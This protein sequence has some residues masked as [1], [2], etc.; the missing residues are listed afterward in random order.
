MYTHI[1]TALEAG[2]RRKCLVQCR[3]TL[4]LYLGT[5]QR[6]MT[7]QDRIRL[8]VLCCS[9]SYDNVLRERCMD[10]WMDGLLD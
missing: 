6:G 3:A 1:Y 5:M 7:W 9:S 10:G 4:H 2:L 8:M